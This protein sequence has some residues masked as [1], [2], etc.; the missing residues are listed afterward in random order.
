M[1][2]AIYVATVAGLVLAVALVA[3]FDLPAIA[4]AVASAGW[5]LVAIT[6]FH[7]VPLTF[8]AA[9][10][11]AV[12]RA[13]W[14]GGL[15]IFLWARWIREAVNNL[16]PVAQVGGDVVGARVLVLHGATGR[17]AGASVIADM[18]VELVTQF[19]FTLMGVGVL[20]LLGG[21]S[22]TV[23]AVLAALAVGAPVLVAFYLSQ[24]LGIVKLLDRLIEKLAMEWNWASLASL[25]NMHDTMW[26]LYRRRRAMVQ[27]F[28]HHMLSWV[29][30]AGEIW[31]ALHFMGVDRSLAAALVLESLGQAVK[32]AAFI[33][34]G[35]IGVQEGG[36]ILLGA[37]FGLSP[38]MALALSIVK[39][40]R[41]LAHGIPAILMWQLVEGRRIVRT[42][43]ARRR[44]ES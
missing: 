1:K 42:V 29:T 3:Y 21:D 25:S 24:R 26:A 22:R 17:L 7:L 41:E 28:I 43:N 5:G 39:R 27:G 35:A 12:A 15:P 36:Y 30:G 32:S 38:E 11:A 31:L 16:L 40:V 23:N 18:T 44:T 10:W 4:R 8:S 34:P 13:E 19:A 14:R 6:L 37:L 9:A 33:V 20:V 2:V